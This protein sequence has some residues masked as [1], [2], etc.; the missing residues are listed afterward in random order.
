MPHALPRPAGASDRL[1]ATLCLLCIATLMVALALGDLHRRRQQ[2][3]QELQLLQRDLYHLLDRPRLLDADGFDQL[4]AL[5]QETRRVLGDVDRLSMAGQDARASLAAEAVINALGR[6]VSQRQAFTD[7]AQLNDRLAGEDRPVPGLCAE[8]ASVSNM[9]RLRSIIERRLARDPEAGGAALD[10]P[11][12]DSAPQLQRAVQ[13]VESFRTS[14]GDALAGMSSL[15]RLPV[16]PPSAALV[17]GLGGLGALL[18]V[19]A[20]ARWLLRRKPALVPMPV[21][22]A[23]ALPEPDAAWTLP[24]PAPAPLPLDL[25]PAAPAL[26]EPVPAAPPLLPAPVSS[27][28]DT[29]PQWLDLVHTVTS[30]QAA[31]RSLVRAAVDLLDA[32][33]ESLGQNADDWLHALSGLADHLLSAREGAVNQALAALA[34]AADPGRQAALERLDQHLVAILDGLAKLKELRS[35]ERAGT[36]DA[37]TVPRAALVRLSS[38][39]GHLNDQLGVIGLDVAALRDG[40]ADLA[41]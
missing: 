8:D 36:T 6:I 4:E 7:L 27:A 24:P 19:L 32:P 28:V 12:A 13:L 14:R 10:V 33:Q 40:G 18:A 31:G 22:A 35:T 9:P 23:A 34:D 37:T 11:G 2:S 25:V 39:L 30:A 41:A 5:S 29:G 1:L 3:L 21:A 15:A 16:Q 26:P 20:A 38:E 17:Q